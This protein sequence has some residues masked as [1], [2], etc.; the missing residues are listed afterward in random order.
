MANIKENNSVAEFWDEKYSE[1]DPNQKVDGNLF[2]ANKSINL[3]DKKIL[4]VAVGTGKE[5][6]RAA[7]MGAEVYGIDISSNAVKNAEEMLKAN[8]LNG[9]MIVGDAANTNFNND[10]FDIIWGCAV[11]HHLDH[12]KFSKELDKILKKNGIALFVDEPTF[13]NPLIKFAYETLFGK[14][15][16]GRRRKFLFFTRRGDEFEKPIDYNDL[17]FYH[18]KFLIEKIPHHFMMFE[19]IAHA[20]FNWNKTI[21]RFF[22]KIDFVIV[23]IMP[24]LKKYTYEYNFV[25]YSNKKNK[26]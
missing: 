1:F 26:I 11:L 15:R 9:N 19:K 5:V 2:L 3:K 16:V 14:G 7:R 23:K 6:V 18:K 4:I 10:F 25:F 24:F 20:I 22:A 12:K 17:S 13:F 21:H 8:N